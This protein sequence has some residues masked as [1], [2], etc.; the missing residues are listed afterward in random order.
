[1]RKPEH[2]GRAARLDSRR[3]LWYRP[4][5]VELPPG[6]SK[7]V[8]I[9]MQNGLRMTT[10]T[11]AIAGVSSSGEVEIRRKYPSIGA[12]GIGQVL[13]SIYE[14]IPAKIC[15]V[16][17]SYLLF[18]LPS[19]PLAILGYVVE[20]V[21]GEKWILTN[22]SIQRW[23][24]LGTRQ[25]QSVSLTDVAE[26]AIETSPGMIFY[27]CGTLHLQDA[28]GKTLMELKG[29]NQ[30]EIFRETLL[31]SRESRTQVEAALATIEA[32]A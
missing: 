15:G 17:L 22:R 28:K 30:P 6:R 19:A 27:R 14:S 10:K 21:F 24:S 4:Y 23:A 13:G 26:I 2:F 3:G 18:V 29:V 11:T 1:M 20:K 25:I 8:E 9:S 7:T 16:K 12:T 31:K 5:L 32:R